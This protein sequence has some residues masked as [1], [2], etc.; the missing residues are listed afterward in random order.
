VLANPGQANYVAANAAIEAIAERR[1]AEALPALAVAWG[2]ISDVGV[3]ARETGTVELLARRFGNQKTTARAALDQLDAMLA[4]PHAVIAPVAVNWG[5]ARQ[6]LSGLASPRFSEL[7]VRAREAAGETGVALRELLL[8]KSPD[9]A[10]AMVRAEL[11]DLIGEVL[12][13]P[14]V[15]MQSEARLA[16]IGIDSLINVEVRLA[17]EERFGAN[18]PIVAISDETTLGDMA[19]TVLRAIG[20]GTQEVQNL[21]MQLALRNEGEGAW[22]TEAADSDAAE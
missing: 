20:V 15:R 11:A 21:A 12:R 2:P 8:Q 19:E 18:L 13:L 1:R 22:L 6:A 9:E 16:D 3:L 4:M 14:A 7:A 10:R 5:Q 17:I